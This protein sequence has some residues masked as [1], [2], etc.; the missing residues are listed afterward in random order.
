MDN[1]KIKD[2]KT[3][4]YLTIALYM[5]VFIAIIL[6]IASFGTNPSIEAMLS[7]II[8]MIILMF[9]ILLVHDT[10]LY[11][12]WEDIIEAIE[13]CKNNKPKNE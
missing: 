12:M 5:L 6:M 3:G 10:T 4:L 7:L 8:I 1:K 2:I 9:L 13:E 11:R